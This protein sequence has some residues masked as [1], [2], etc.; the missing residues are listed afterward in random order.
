MSELQVLIEGLKELKIQASEK[1]ISQINDFFNF[2]QEWNSKIDLSSIIEK[3]DFM[4]KHVLDSAVALKYFQPEKK[5]ADIG[6]GGGFPGVILKILNPAL[7]ITLLEVIQKKVAYLRELNQM[8]NLGLKILNPSCEKV[9]KDYDV[10]TC[11]AFSNLEKIYNQ[12]KRILKKK[13]KV[14]AY[15]GKLEKINEESKQLKKKI[16]VIPL[17]VPFLEGE[18]NLVI[19]FI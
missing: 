7:D 3:R 9:G 18:R 5:I 17:Y 15:K 14:L 4:V 11:R 13:G 16:E 12:G 1:Q 19:F 2:Y 8:M 6:S 10:L